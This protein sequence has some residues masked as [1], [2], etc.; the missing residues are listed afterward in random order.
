M[1]TP[2]VTGMSAPNPTATVFVREQRGQA[3]WEAFWRY[4][5][6]QLKRRLGA[7]WLDQDASG[8]WTRRKGRV[9]EGYLDERRAHVAAAELVAAYVEQAD[10]EERTD[11]E[12]RA[13]GVTFREVAQAY[14]SWL[15]DVKGAKPATLL[16]HRSVLAEPGI[17]YKRGEGVTRGHVMKALGDLPAAKI[18]TRDVEAV[19][20]TVSATD[21][22]ARTINKHR[23]IIGA[24]FAYGIKASTFGLP[25]NPAREADK[26]REPHRGALVFY[27][28]EEVEALARAL[29]D[30]RHREASTHEVSEQERDARHAEDQQDAEMVRVSAYAGLRLGELLALR[31]RDVN[32]A[33]HALTVG[34]AMSAGVESSTK[35]GRVRRLPLPD[36]AAAALDRMSRREDFTG[37][38]ERVFC[39]PLGRTLDPSALRRRY[40]RAQAAAGLRALRWHDLRH[41]YGSL[42]AA[43][44]VDL[45]TIQAAMG[46]SALATTG[47]YLH[48]RPAA[49]QAEVFTRAFESRPQAAARQNLVETFGSGEQI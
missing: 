49:D 34:R 30:G 9:R 3:F 26:R 11:R 36:Q 41:T 19:L 6:K 43:A 37:A 32:F 5:G 44:G 18:T 27:S 38:D 46:H 17:P 47:R 12:R 35:S 40:R 8:A 48:A 16:N 2:E 15:Q 7:A 42:L 33:G 45:V 22:S 39:N 14:L 24:I 10:N 29:A 23:A 25:A 1:D 31:W 20:A 28:V 4:R 21:A 13:A